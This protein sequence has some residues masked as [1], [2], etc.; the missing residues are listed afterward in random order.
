MPIIK[1]PLYINLNHFYFYR[2]YFSRFALKFLWGERG[3][4]V[5]DRTR[6]LNIPD[7]RK[8][9][10]NCYDNFEDLKIISGS[11]VMIERRELTS[12]VRL[13]HCI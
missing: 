11:S 9:Y 5:V 8:S 6:F 10:V 13:F 1:R 2:T 3:K 7:G 4:G 12:Q